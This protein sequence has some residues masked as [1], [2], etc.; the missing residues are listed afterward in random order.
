[1]SDL[2]AVRAELLGAEAL[3]IRAEAERDTL[4]A[5]IR[6]NALAMT[7]QSIG[8]YRTALLSYA[9]TEG[10]ADAAIVAARKESDRE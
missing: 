8:Q 9:L 2:F 6:D 1:L 4:L 7:C 5:R 10:K 3:R